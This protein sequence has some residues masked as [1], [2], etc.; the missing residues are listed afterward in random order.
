M[1]KNH[2]LP[3]DPSRLLG[4]DPRSAATQQEAVPIPAF[5]GTRML[6]LLWIMPPTGEFTRK[7]PD[8]TGKK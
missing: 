2:N 8:S 3:K 1:G 4:I 7:A 5:A 6:P